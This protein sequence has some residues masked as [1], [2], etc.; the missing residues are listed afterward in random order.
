MGGAVIVDPNIPECLV[1]RHEY[2]RRRAGLPVDPE[3]HHALV[4]SVADTAQDAAPQDAIPA[5]VTAEQ[6]IRAKALEAATAAT[7]QWPGQDA[8]VSRAQRFEIYIKTGR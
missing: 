3:P 6:W 2:R 1:C 4:A 7:A 8:T 5:G